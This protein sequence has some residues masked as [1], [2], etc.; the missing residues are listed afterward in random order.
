VRHAEDRVRHLRQR[1]LQPLAVAVRAD[2]QLEP[3]V[4]REAGHAP[5]RG[6]APSECPTRIDAGA[7]AGLLGIHGKA[8]A[9]A[10]PSGSPC[11]WRCAHLGEADRLDSP[12]A[13]PRGSRRKSKWR[14][15]M[16]SNGICSGRTRLLK[17]SSLAS[18]PSSRASASSVTSSAKHTPVRATPR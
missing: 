15:A 12:G 17:R 4:G 6:P 2:P 13:A 14:L 3:A 7:V 11:R 18:R 9:D 8:D 10:R 1:G 5:A 16:L